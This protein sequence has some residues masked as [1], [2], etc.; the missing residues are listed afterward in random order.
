MIYLGNQQLRSYAQ[1]LCRLPNYVQRQV[2]ED[3]VS[4]LSKSL[5]CH[6]QDGSRYGQQLYWIQNGDTRRGQ[7]GAE[8]F[9]GTFGHS[10]NKRLERQCEFYKTAIRR[11]G[12]G[13]LLLLLLGTPC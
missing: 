4:R 3:V 9:A 7:W 10:L 11:T 5:R 2:A 8:N 12:G 13:T 1:R 6:Y